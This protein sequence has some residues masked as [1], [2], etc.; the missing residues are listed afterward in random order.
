MELAELDRQLQENTSRA[1]RREKRKRDEQL[2][3]EQ[4]ADVEAKLLAWRQTIRT[5]DRKLDELDSAGIGYLFGTLFGDRQDRIA[6][7]QERLLKQKLQRDECAAALEP[8]QKQLAGM[9][10]ELAD[11]ADVEV[12][13]ATLLAAKDQLL[14]GR[15]DELAAKLLQSGDRLAGLVSLHRE[16]EEAIDAGKFVL[17]HLEASVVDLKGAASWGYMDSFGGGILNGMAK[18]GS[19]NDARE[20]VHQAQLCLRRFVRELRDVE[21]ELPDVSMSIDEFSTFADLF[22]DGLIVD[23]FVQSRINAAMRTVEKADY[24]VRSIAHELWKRSV[25]V[26]KERD[27]LQAERRALIEQAG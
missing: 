9:R 16:L 12:Q 4:L 18:H 21:V 1:R 26:A 20:H 7:E 6:D 15:D 8:M 24:Q 19:F 25:S 14:R 23:W 10:T 13:R 5:T 2:L 27:E 11:L 22:F 17:A 3:L